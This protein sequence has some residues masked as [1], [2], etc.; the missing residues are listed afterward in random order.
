MN[1]TNVLEKVL[2]V[3]TTKDCCKEKV[4][5]NSKFVSRNI[6]IIL[7]ADPKTNDVSGTP[8]IVRQWHSGLFDTVNTR[9]RTLL[10][11]GGGFL[12]RR[13]LFRGD[14]LRHLRFCGDNF[15]H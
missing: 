12:L 7:R 4:P 1:T 2:A 6:T 5:R 8:K 11:F 3:N 10:F 15:W 9:L 13:R 14:N